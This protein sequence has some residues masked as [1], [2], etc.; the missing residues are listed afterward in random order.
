[1]VANNSFQEFENNE[2][3]ST[4]S[5]VMN[6]KDKR[7]NHQ[8]KDKPLTVSLKD[9]HSEGNIYIKSICRVTVLNL[10]ILEL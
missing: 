4:Q 8:G 10:C 6:K 5:K 2:N 3:A 9:F 1:M 7:K